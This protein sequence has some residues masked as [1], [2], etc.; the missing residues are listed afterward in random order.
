MKLEKAINLLISL[1]VTVV[2]LDP[3]DSI[4]RLKMP[5]FALLILLLI[6]KYKKVS[7]T[8]VLSIL[9]IY[10]ICIFTT[11]FGL[12]RGINTDLNFAVGVYKG[13]T[14]TVLLLWSSKLRFLH[15]LTFPTIIISIIVIIIYILTKTFPEIG[16]VIYNFT[17]SEAI[18]IKT[19]TRYFIGL[20]VLSVFYQTSPLCI[21]VAGV[22]LQ[23]LTKGE[24]NTLANILIGSSAILVLIL[25]G[26]RMNMLAAIVLTGFILIQKM[27][28]TRYGKL[29]AGIITIFSTIAIILIINMLLSDTGE[30]SLGVKSTLVEAFNMH[31]SKNPWLLIF[32]EGPGATFD[33]LGVRGRFAVQSELTYLDLIR[34]FGIPFTVIIMLVYLYPVRLIYSKRRN[35]EY[36]SVLILAY[37]LYLVIAGTNPL[38]I[39]STGMLALLVMYSYAFN[40]YYESNNKK[41]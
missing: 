29:L 6:I 39:S 4:F 38:L 23:K 32:G 15:N 7:Y 37:L 11:S 12:A 34:W 28:K 22:Y 31:S 40:P 35:L 36:S 27:W 13:F 2:V 25:S 26:T 1:F 9:I 5:V 10:L 17:M 24:K 18:P 41:R 33:S 14:M 16:G 3:L 30:H 19:S 21:F 8:S 20:E